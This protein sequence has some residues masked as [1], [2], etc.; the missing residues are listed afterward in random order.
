MGCRGERAPCDSDHPRR[1]GHCRPANGLGVTVQDQH[2]AHARM[3]QTQRAADRQGATWALENQDPPRRPAMRRDPRALRARR[4][5]QRRELPRLCRAGIPTPVDRLEPGSSEIRTD[6]S[7]SSAGRQL[8]ARASRSAFSLLSSNDVLRTVPPVPFN[9]SS[10]LSPVT[11]LIR[12]NRAALPGC[13]LSESF[14]INSS[15]TP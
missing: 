1:H 11:F 8:A 9:A 15:L 7:N 14:F 2:D 5:D 3:E 10:I 12:T 4:A 13:K 6:S